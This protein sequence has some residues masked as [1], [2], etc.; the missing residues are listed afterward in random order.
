[1]GCQTQISLDNREA[2]ATQIHTSNNVPQ[3]HAYLK[4]PVGQRGHAAGHQ[5]IQAFGAPDSQVW[6][7]V[8]VGHDASR[9]NRTKP[10]ASLQ[11]CPHNIAD[12]LRRLCFANKVNDGNGQL[13]KAHTGNFNAKLREDWQPCNCQQAYDGSPAKCRCLSNITHGCRLD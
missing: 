12:F 11:V 2:L 9:V 8:L 10:P 5:S 4:P 13:G 3:S 1:M 6:A 7:S